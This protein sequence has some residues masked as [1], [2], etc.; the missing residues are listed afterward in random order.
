M[1]T[2]IA[3]TLQG[4]EPLLTEELLA[5]GAENLVTLKRGVQFEGDKRLLYKAN[6]WLRTAIRILVPIHQFEAHSEEELYDGIKAMDWSE[7]LSEGDTLAVD[8][9]VFSERFTHSHYIS[10]KTKDAICDFFRERKGKRPNVDLELPT[11]RVHIYINQLNVGVYLDSSGT[12]L[13]KRGY[14]ANHHEAPINEVLAAG[15]LLHSGW[16]GEGNFLDPFCGSGTFLIEAAMIAYNIAPNR[17]RYS[18][19]FHTWRDFDDKL[20]QDVRLEA[21]R[22]IKPYKGRIEGSDWSETAVAMAEE[23]IERARLSDKIEVT[24]MDFRRI[25]KRHGSGMVIMNPPYGERMQTDTDILDFYVKIGNMFKQCFVGYRCALISSHKEALRGFGL[26]PTQKIACMNGKLECEFA[27]YDIY[28]GTKRVFT[29][30][31]QQE[32]ENAKA[33][34]ALEAEQKA[35]EA[36]NKPAEVEKPVFVAP[37]PEKPAPKPQTEAIEDEKPD[38]YDEMKAF[39]SQNAGKPEYQDDYKADDETA[40]ET[41]E[42]VEEM[43]VI[44]A[45]Q[46]EEIIEEMP[47]IAATQTEE[48]IEE[49]PIIAATQTEEIAEVAPKKTR[50]KAEPKVTEPAEIV[51]EPVKKTRKKAEPKAAVLTEVIAD[52]NAVIEEPVK[53]TRK[54]AEPKVTEPAEIGEEPVKKTRK[55]AEPKVTE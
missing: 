10:L 44:A 29:E 16:K 36:Q 6:L 25:P 52:E 28:E 18:F 30:E 2:Y 34:A 4:F 50:K 55:K 14:R 35:L 46:T 27:I 11:L 22:A 1:N 49:M 12:P 33:K 7:H 37:K 13:F 42:I 51:A 41:T 54:K 39:F 53:K 19:G 38:I 24:E 43:P 3:K 20:W 8:S 31:M 17:L 21:N 45:T 5:L 15:L 47:I 40:D 26:R 48:I 32:H 23:N 9:T